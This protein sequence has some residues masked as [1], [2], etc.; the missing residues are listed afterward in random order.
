M[1]ND[2]AMQVSDEWQCLLKSAPTVYSIEG[3]SQNNPF[4]ADF[5]EVVLPLF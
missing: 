3:K 1:K 2:D 5:E 4:G